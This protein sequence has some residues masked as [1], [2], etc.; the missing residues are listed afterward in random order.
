M[1]QALEGACPKTISSAFFG[2]ELDV[3]RDELFNRAE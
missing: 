2:V 3:E 1:G